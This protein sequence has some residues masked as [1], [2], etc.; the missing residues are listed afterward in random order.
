MK[1][2]QCIVRHH[3]QGWIACS[4]RPPE[5][6]KTNLSRWSKLAPHDMDRVDPEQRRKKIL[7]VSELLANYLRALER[8][9]NLRRGPKFKRYESLPKSHLQRQFPTHPLGAVGKRQQQIDRRRE[10]VNRIGMSGSL[11]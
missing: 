10:G 5:Q 8:L 2:A 7:R 11:D 4:L 3:E 9:T 1:E 6:L